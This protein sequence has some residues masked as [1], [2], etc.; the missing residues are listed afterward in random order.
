MNVWMA[1]AAIA[2]AACIIV[3]AVCIRQRM[4]IAQLEAELQQLRIELEGIRR[5]NV[6][7]RREIAGLCR[8]LEEEQ[9]YSD[10]LSEELDKQY[11][12]L[13]EAEQRVERAEIR[14]TDAEKE[15][16]AGRMRAEQLQQQLRQAHME[17]MAQEQL[18]QDI[19]RDRDATIAQ[20]QEKHRKHRLKKKKE[21]LDQQISFDDLLGGKP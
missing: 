19:I 6:D 5:E 2:V 21:V 14:R 20:M 15:I 17:Q 8:D 3:L 7:F 16:Y 4:R 12:L 13:L 10:Q 18:Y 9:Q 1:S 11:Q